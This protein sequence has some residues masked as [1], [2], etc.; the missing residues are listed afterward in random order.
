MKHTLRVAFCAA[1]GFLVLLP[2]IWTPLDATV[3]REMSVEEL[4]RL[5]DHVVRGTVLGQ[6]SQWSEDGV[7]I[8]TYV[9]V[10]IHERVKGTRPLPEVVQIVLPGGEVNG[11]RMAVIGGPTFRDSEELFL[12]LAPYSDDPTQA[13]HVVLI[14][15]K[16]G[17]MPVLADPEGGEPRVL[18][19]FA[20]LEFARLKQDHGQSELE[21]TPGP[22]SRLI[23][24]SQFKKRIVAAG[25]PVE[26]PGRPE[27]GNRP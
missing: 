20:G 6:V 7:G 2:A 8:L 5:S 21:I 27:R 22:P 9:D 26:P 10:L 1:A 18:R 13:D 24:V 14:G 23:P 12:F 19:E 16:M 11:T 15:G 25:R 17:R 4:A 3:M